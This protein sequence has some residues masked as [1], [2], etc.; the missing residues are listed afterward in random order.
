MIQIEQ[1]KLF[2][3]ILTPQEISAIYKFQ[4]GATIQDVVETVKISRAHAERLSRKLKEEYTDD[5][6]QESSI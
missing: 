6:L 1:A 5:A 3:H 2:A 4:D